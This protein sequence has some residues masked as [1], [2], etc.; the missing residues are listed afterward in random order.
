MEETTAVAAM[1]APW[2]GTDTVSDAEAR[3]G[4]GL[5][6]REDRGWSGDSSEDRGWSSDGLASRARSGDGRQCRVRVR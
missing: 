5:A 3:S 1:A 6:S 4:D 2:P